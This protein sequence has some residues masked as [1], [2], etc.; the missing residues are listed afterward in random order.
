MTDFNSSDDLDRVADYFRVL[1]DPSR[2]SMLRCLL[3]E[4]E[5]NVGRI[6]TITKQS[7]ANTSKHLKLMMETG[8][9]TRRKVGLLVYYRV[10]DPVVEQVFRLVSSIVRKEIAES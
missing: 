1:A 6:G 9:L 3:A 8:L 4:G 5:M 7:Q 10:A 2:L